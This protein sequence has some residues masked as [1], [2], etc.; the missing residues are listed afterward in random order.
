MYIWLLRQGLCANLSP[1]DTT[2]SETARVFFGKVC[3]CVCAG[4]L[5][6]K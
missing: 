1:A 4:A 5:E 2:A 3:V 6:Y